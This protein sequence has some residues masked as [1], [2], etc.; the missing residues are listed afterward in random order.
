MKRSAPAA[1]LLTAAF[2]ILIASVGMATAQSTAERLPPS[3]GG[4]AKALETVDRLTL[5]AQ[6]NQALAR[7]ADLESIDRFGVP[8]RFAVPVATTARMDDRGTWESRAD[9]SRLWRMRVSSPGALSLN[10]HFNQ[11]ELPS[12]ARM[13]LYNRA[14]D[15]IQGPFDASN[16]NARGGLWTPIVLGDETIVEVHVPAGAPTPIVRLGS[17]QHAFR[18]LS[19]K[20][21]ACNNDVICPEGDD[22]RPQIRAAARL[23]YGGVVLCSGQLVNNTEEDGRPLFL[24]AFHCITPFLGGPPDFSLIDSTVTYWNFESPVCGQLSGGSLN[25]T[26]IGATM[27][28]GEQVTDFMLLELSETPPADFNVYYAGWDVTGNAPNAA[29]GIH[30][31]S[32]DEKAISF[33]ND[34]LT[35]DTEFFPGGTHWTIGGWEDGTTEGGSSGSCIYD[36]ATGQCVGTLTGGFAACVGQTRPED[37]YGKLSA[38]W[39]AGEADDEQLRAHL[40]PLDLGVNRLAGMEPVDDGGDNGGGDGDCTPSDT[41]FCLGANDRFRAE[42]DFVGPRGPGTAKG[43][44]ESSDSGIFYF[45]REDNWEVVVKVLSNCGGLTDSFW[46]FS[47]GATT[48]EWTLTVTDT[49]TGESKSYTTPERSGRPITNTMAFACP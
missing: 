24:S 20:Q 26:V 8:E 42:V 21:G 4:D 32:G 41:A 44:A 14:G 27:V 40:D 2:L 39:E 5:P 46:V 49:M 37:Y 23:T 13:W 15:H 34:P 11:F 16:A 9:G 19:G 48:L 31:P 47:A 43:A 3:F 6:D 22:W 7:Q 18:G 36:P 35:T 30:H 17:V 25:E 10:I 29:V 1:V 33:D 38:A 28:A 12:G 45:F